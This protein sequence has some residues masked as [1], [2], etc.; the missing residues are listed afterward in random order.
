MELALLDFRMGYSFLVAKTYKQ[1]IRKVPTVCGKEQTKSTLAL[2]RRAAG[3]DNRIFPLWHQILEIGTVHRP[4]RTLPPRQGLVGSGVARSGIAV[5]IV[6][7]V[8][9]PVVAVPVVA[10]S[11][12][13]VAAVVA[14]TVVVVVVIV[15]V[16]I[17]DGE[18]VFFFLLIVVVIGAARTE[19]NFG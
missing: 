19:Q 1:I 15:V 8:G 9:V 10:V 6:V 2:C 4:L 5:V 11:A 16:G 12:V 17:V 13:V 18:V 14:S 3:T 7:V